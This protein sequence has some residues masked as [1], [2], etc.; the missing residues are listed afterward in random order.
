MGGQQNALHQLVSFILGA[1]AAAVLLFFLTTATSGARFTGISSWAN[2]TTGFD[3]DAPV[4]AAPA[5][6]ANHADAKGAAAEQEDELQRLLRAVADE[7]RTV[8]MTSVNEAWAAQDSLLDLFLESFR[9][10]ERIAHFVDHLLVVALDGGALERCRAVHPHCY[11]LPTAA[12][13]NLSGE[14]VFMSKDYIDLVWS[15]VRLQQRI[16]ELGY[17]FLF[18]LP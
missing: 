8:I 9:S 4:Q 15:K 1:S 11:L 16:L 13:R 14:K 2:G 17:N 18:T 5:T 3:D 6:R 10:G 12:A 7:D